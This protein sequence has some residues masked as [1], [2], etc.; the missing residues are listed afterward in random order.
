M[1]YEEKK[2]IN[3]IHYTI[4]TPCFEEY[5]NSSLS[6]YWKNAFLKMIEGYYKKNKLE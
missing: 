5:K 1:E 2:N 3:L 6:K 4:G